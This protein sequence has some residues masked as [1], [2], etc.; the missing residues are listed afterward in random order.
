[1][2]QQELLLIGDGSLFGKFRTVSV[3]LLKKKCYLTECDCLARLT[4]SAFG[5]TGFPSLKK[6]GA[7]IQID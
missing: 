6:I 5:S 2:K 7:A 3:T 1:L 4:V